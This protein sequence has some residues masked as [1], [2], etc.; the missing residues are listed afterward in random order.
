MNGCSFHVEAPH[1]AGA[2][3]VGGRTKEFIGRGGLT[4]KFRLA[5]FVYTGMSEAR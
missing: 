3:S 5:T 2:G 4:E 1:A